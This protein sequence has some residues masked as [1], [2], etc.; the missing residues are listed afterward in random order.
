[1]VITCNGTQ[2]PSQ[3]RKNASVQ[4]TKGYAKI[5]KPRKELRKV[6]FVKKLDGKNITFF[7]PKKGQKGLKLDEKKIQIFIKTTPQAGLMELLNRDS[8]REVITQT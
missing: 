4:L 2:A 1:M 5:K 8:G 7:G 3:N 6:V